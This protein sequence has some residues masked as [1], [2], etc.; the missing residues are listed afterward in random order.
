MDQLLAAAGGDLASVKRKI[1]I[2]DKYWNEPLYRVDIA[3]PLLHDARLP[4]GFERGANEFFRG[5]GYT[6]GGLPEIVTGRI[7]FGGY[8][9][10]Y[11]G[12][13]P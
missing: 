5:G 6:S 9:A 7:P 3:N 10:Y 12:V 1:A 8:R 4:S 2:P 11:A 13:R